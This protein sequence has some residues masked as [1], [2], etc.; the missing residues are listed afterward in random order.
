MSK[1]VLN[2]KE[3]DTEAISESAKSQLTSY[4]YT[5]SEITRIQLLLASLQTARNA[6]ASALAVELKEKEDESDIEIDLDGLD[7]NLSFE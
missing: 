5:T 6:Y 4:Q 1:F 2:G 7:E 3:Y